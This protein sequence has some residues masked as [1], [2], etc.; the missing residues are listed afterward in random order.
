MTHTATRGESGEAIMKSTREYGP[1]F[2]DE[3][4]KP[5]RREGNGWADY[6]GWSGAQRVTLPNPVRGVERPGAGCTDRLPRRG[7][8]Y[9]GA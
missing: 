9:G 4:Q 8:A 2:A 5:A 7:S 1:R 6:V 3:S